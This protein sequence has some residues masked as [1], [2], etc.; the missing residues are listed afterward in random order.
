VSKGAAEAPVTERSQLANNRLKLTSR[1][2][3]VGAWRLRARRSLA[4]ALD[5]Q[6]VSRNE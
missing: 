3:P 1:G 5:R 2:R 4:G 6:G